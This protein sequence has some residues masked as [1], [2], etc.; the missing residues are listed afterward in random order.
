METSTIILLVVLGI[1][2]IFL[3]W[4]IYYVYKLEKP[5]PGNCDYLKVSK[6]DVKWSPDCSYIQELVLDTSLQTPTEPLFLTRFSSSPTL[7]QPWGANV[8][9]KYKYVNSKTGGY[10]KASPWTQSPIS[11]GSTNLP[12]QSGNCSSIQ[13]SGKDSCKSNLAQLKINSLAYPLGSD[14]YINVHRYVSPLNTTTPPVDSVDGKIVGM[15]LP[16]GAGGGTFIDLSTSP[17]DEVTCSNIAG[18]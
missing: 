18:C 2:A 7:G 16:N 12:C 11:A 13:Y 3:V 4:L 10:G 9:Y 17:C 6:P 5:L 14:N 8:W 1:I 15:V